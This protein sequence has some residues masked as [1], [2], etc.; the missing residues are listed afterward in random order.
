M[1]TSAPE[2]ESS[3]AA[4]D[5]DRLRLR[6]AQAEA[7][8]KEEAYWAG[9]IGLVPIPL[10]DVVGITAVEMRTIRRIA[11]VYDAKYDNEM[12]QNVVLSLATGMGATWLGRSVVNTVLRSI[13][14][15]NVI[16]GVVSV[17][18]T[19][20]P[21]HYGIGRYVINHLEAGRALSDLVIKPVTKPA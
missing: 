15:L 16:A 21:L 3:T 1:S 7:I 9:G 17:P 18:L 13:P 20:L 12:L 2:T 14:G 8:L 6:R 5:L 10:A 19:V 4:Q 11:D